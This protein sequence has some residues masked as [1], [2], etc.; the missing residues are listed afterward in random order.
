MWTEF[1]DRKT[2]VAAFVGFVVGLVIGLPVLGWWLWPVNWLNDVQMVADSYHLHGNLEL[3]KEQLKGWSKEDLRAEVDKLL[4]EAED[5]KQRQRLEKLAKALE[6]DNF[7]PAPG[8]ERPSPPAWRRFLPLGLAFILAI[9]AL[10][11]AAMVVSLMIRRRE[12]PVSIPGPRAP[13]KEPEGPVS[14]TF[15]ATYKRGDDNYDETFGIESP[16]G[17]F[18]GECGL[19]ISEKLGEG[20][21][22]KVT[23][24]ELWL[25]D[26]GD[27]RTVT[28][29]LMSK[30]A[31]GDEALRAKLAPK[32]ELV[33]AELGEPIILETANLRL[34]ARI[35]DMAYEPQAIPPNSYFSRLSMELLVT[36]KEEATSPA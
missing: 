7:L 35:T 2:L 33:L 12:E 3:A 27:I 21:P 9:A 8:A 22:A 18:L 36:L 24:F 17:E 6:K 23:A 25:F 16:T 31:Y 28:K 1:L 19:S 20:T 4:S 32:G 14:H 29:V 30:Y 15:T 34:E 10:A 13:V 26:K 11:G 5:L